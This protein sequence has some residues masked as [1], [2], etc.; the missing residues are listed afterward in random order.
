MKRRRKIL[1]GRSLIKHHPDL[2]KSALA[3][4]LGIAR[5]TL[6]IQSSK[7]SEKDKAY[8]Q[9]ILEVLTEHPHYGHRRI[10]LEINRNP[11]LVKRIMHKY[12]LKAKKRRKRPRKRADEGKSAS[13]IPNRIKGLCPIFPSTIWVGDFTYLDFHGSFAY[14]ATVMDLYTREIVGATVG[15]YHSS[16]LVI[17]ALQN[18]LSKRVKPNIFHSD[19]GSEY[20]SKQLRIFLLAHRILPSQSHKAHPW[21]NGHQESFYGRFKQEIGNL[22]RFEHL[23]E[24]IEAVHLQI[25]YYNYR[26]IHSA[27]K[28]TPRKKFEQSMAKLNIE[29]NEKTPEPGV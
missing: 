2:S 9:Q 19:Q 4:S 23:D 1:L 28:M 5:S 3:K 13:G 14:L 16:Q 24:L 29:I 17:D 10:A 12:G 15:L 21:E 22:N 26:R 6:Y 18:A 25:Y 7:Q 20:D 11:K 27:L 8:Q